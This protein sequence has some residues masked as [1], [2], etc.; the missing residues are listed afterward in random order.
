MRGSEVKQFAIDVAMA[1]GAIPGLE[2]RQ[3]RRRIAARKFLAAVVKDLKAAGKDALVITSPRQPAIVHA[4]ALLMNQT[5]GSL[6]NTIEIVK[7]AYRGSRRKRRGRAEGPGWGNVRGPGLDAGDAG[8]KSG[9]HRARR[10]AVRREPCQGR[11]LPFTWAYDPTKPPRC[12][13]GIC[14]RRIISK[15]GATRSPA[16]SPP[17]SSP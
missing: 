1:L 6:G 14:P 17:S 9:L 5:L 7:V 15:A 16:A 13:S 3:Q 2:R 12:P 8:R 4:L 10:F 11:Q